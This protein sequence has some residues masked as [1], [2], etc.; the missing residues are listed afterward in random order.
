MS[1]TACVV[2]NSTKLFTLITENFKV[3]D[4]NYKYLRALFLVTF[5]AVLFRIE[6]SERQIEFLCVLRCLYKPSETAVN[7]GA[8]LQDYLPPNH[9]AGTWFK[10]QIFS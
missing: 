6:Q 7:T 2:G 8:I 10:T 4:F 5:H 9:F 1:N 3:R